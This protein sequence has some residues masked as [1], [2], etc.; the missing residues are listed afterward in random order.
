MTFPLKPTHRRI[1]YLDH[2]ATT[3]TD[4]AV[5]KAMVPFWTKHFANPSALYSLGQT[6]QVAIT[7]ARTT[8]ATAL[9]TQPDCLV[10]TSGGTEANNLALTG[11][12]KALKAET[13]KTEKLHVITTALEHH[14]VL[15]PLRDL[16]Q[17]GVEVTYL[18][19]NER[20]EVKA[21][22]VLKEIRPN[23]RLVSI[24][25]ANNEIGTINPLAEIG[26][27]ILKYRKQHKTPYP[28]FHT[29]ACQAVGTL[30][31]HT[32]RLHVD[33]LT[34]NGSKIYGPKG[35]GALFVRRGVPLKPILNG[36][37]QENKLR[38][39]TENVP[40]IVGFAKAV[41]L[42]QKN[43]N[44]ERARQAKLRDYLWQ[45]IQRK[46]PQV[47]LNGPALTEE[48]L[49]NNLNVRFSGLEG[50]TFVLYLDSYGIMAATGSACATDS[51]DASHV[52]TACGLS[53]V[54]AKSSVRFTL[55]KQTTKADLDYVLKCLPG[56]VAG[57]RAMQQ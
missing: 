6:A 22:E 16:A 11:V 19:V 54:D 56:I 12:I 7:A 29:D 36:G 25:Y 48:R 30:D 52:L 43:Q 10:F 15:E 32:E 17:Q 1:V 27:E 4:P 9:F 26:R 34:L 28:Y 53:S 3:P 41:E 35:V 2:A 33:L 45:Q 39:G 55:G 44:K 8:V 14:S 13:A 20:G 42:M 40:G 5:V 38:S 57:V 51:D 18:P 49:S 47:F 24:M 37:G 31:I 21:S 46:I 50:E 23:T